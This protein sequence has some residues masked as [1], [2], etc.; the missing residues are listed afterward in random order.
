M[1]KVSCSCVIARIHEFMLQDKH[2]CFTV[3]LSGVIKLS[4]LPRSVL[5]SLWSSFSNI[6]IP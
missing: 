4:K 5:K 3:Y 2:L 1:S 6:Y